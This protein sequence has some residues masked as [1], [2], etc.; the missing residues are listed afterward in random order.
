MGKLEVRVVPRA[1]RTEVAVG[2]RGV[3]VRVRA[4]PEDGRATDEARRA[5]AGALDV[6]ASAI[7]VVRGARS[8]RKL[9]EVDGIDGSEALQ[10][11]R[12]R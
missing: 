10:R 12:D 2:E 1:G 9:F 6:P 7:S 8:R 3:V 5:L 11:L 4:A